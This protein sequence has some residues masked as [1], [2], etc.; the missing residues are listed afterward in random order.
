MNLA[1]K[2]IAAL[3]VVAIAVFASVLA[4]PSRPATEARVETLSG[5]QVD[6][7]TRRGA[8]TVVSFWATWCAPCRREMPEL[9]AAQRRFGPRGYETIAIAVRDRREAVAQYAAEH[10]LPFRVA[11][12]ESGELARRF[13]NVRITPTVFVI[14]R[15]GRVLKRYVGEV[16]LEEFE[17]LIEAAL[18][19][20]QNTKI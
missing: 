11:I 14:G 13:G 1:T 15:D 6:L 8:V 20:P 7:A 4:M 16:P 12:D 19:A 9:V 18:A 3:A 5:E 2:V 17:R 10:A